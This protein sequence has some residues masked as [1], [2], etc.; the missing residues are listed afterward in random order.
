MTEEDFVWIF[1]NSVPMLFDKK[2]VDRQKK[3]ETWLDLYQLSQELDA[4]IKTEKTRLNEA[5]NY[6]T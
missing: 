4:A 3:I 1:V 6:V 2:N 5:I